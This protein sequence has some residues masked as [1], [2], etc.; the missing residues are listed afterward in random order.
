MGWYLV[1]LVLFSPD[2]PAITRLGTESEDD[3]F[4]FHVMFLYHTTRCEFLAYIP[5]DLQSPDLVRNSK[6]TS[7]PCYISIPIV[8]Q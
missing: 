3:V 7:V 1:M 4:I 6:I 5:T 8:T 2:G